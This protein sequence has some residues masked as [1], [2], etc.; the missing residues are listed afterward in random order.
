[1]HSGR[2]PLFKGEGN[3][4]G[5]LCLYAAQMGIIWEYHCC[6]GR[7]HM[8]SPRSSLLASYDHGE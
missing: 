6:C 5:L 8:C 1:M 2:A 4:G 7:Q 3:G